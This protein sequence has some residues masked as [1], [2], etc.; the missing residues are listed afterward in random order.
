MNV[1]A[2][3]DPGAD[4]DLDLDD[5]DAWVRHAHG[6]LSGRAPDEPKPLDE[7]PPPGADPLPVEDLYDR[8]AASGLTYGP[9]FQGVERAWRQ[10]DELF[11]EITLPEDQH[12]AAARFGAHPALLDAALHL[13][14]L[15]A[16]SGDGGDGR[17]TAPGGPALPFAASGV[18][19]FR[20][21]ATAAHVRL[22]RVDGTAVS[23]LVTD[24]AAPRWPP[25]TA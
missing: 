12:A 22:S 2:R 20:T 18:T 13:L 11:G 24:G 7:W 5:P 9:T 3:P 14:G 17:R 19:L 15:D 21:G 10:D 8:M 1:H 23:V 4:G 25:S 6:V 16:P